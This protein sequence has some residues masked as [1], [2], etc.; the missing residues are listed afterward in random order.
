[1]RGRLHSPAKAAALIVFPHPGGPTSRIFRLGD[2]P[3]WRRR[4]RCRYCRTTCA[5]CDDTSRSRTMS[6]KCVVGYDAVT[7][8]TNSPAGR[9]IGT[10]RGDPEGEGSLRASSKRRLRSSA[11][12]VSPFLALFAAI[13]SA[14]ARNRSSSPA[15]WLLSS[16]LSCSGVA[17]IAAQ[18]PFYGTPVRPD[19]TGTFYR[20]LLGRSRTSVS[21]TDARKRLSAASSW[22]TWER[23]HVSTFQVAAAIELGLSVVDVSEVTGFPE[24]LDGRVKALHPLVHG[25]SWGA[26]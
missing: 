3:W 7:R 25:G 5:S 18:D 26:R 10:A 20:I 2:S 19:L 23:C 1:M 8:P 9:A 24:M 15:T 6:A 21:A 13:C 11:N 12:R 16:A 4:S 17:I 14:I 22:R